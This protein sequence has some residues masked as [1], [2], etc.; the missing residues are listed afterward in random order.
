MKRILTYIIAALASSL[1]VAA[2]PLSQLADSAYAKED[3]R[4]AADLYTQALEE[5]G[6]SSTLYYNLGNAYYRLDKPGQ[7]ILNY[8]RAL[9]LNPTD[10]DTRTNLDFVNSRIQ[11]RPE[12]DSSFFSNL[13]H[14]IMNKLMPDS[15]AWVTFGLFIVLLGAVALYIFANSIT[16]R[17]TGFF[18]GIAVFF[19]FA[20]AL[21]LARGSVA[22]AQSHNHAIVIVPTTHLSS[23]PRSA[24]GTTEKV[25]PIHE[26]TKVEIVDSVA[27]PDDPTSGKW[28]NVKI[29]NTSKA[30]LRA[31]DVERI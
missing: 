30:W 28:Y 24:R 31:A 29:N 7:A 19:I 25:V 15:W 26:G 16:L 20:Y 17:K 8:E 2:S 1:S 21:T 27:T 3:Y 6:P 11:D 23:T 5:N 12:D 10:E 18:G 13:H 22:S 9:R 4:Q 14:G